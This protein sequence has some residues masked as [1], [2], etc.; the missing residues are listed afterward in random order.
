MK[1]LFL[2]GGAVLAL[3]ACSTAPKTFYASASAYD[4][5]VLAAQAYVALPACGGGVNPCSDAAT[6]ARIKAAVAAASAAVEAA[7]SAEQS[8]TASSAQ[9]AAAEAAAAAAVTQLQTLVTVAK[10]AAVT[11]K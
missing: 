11:A 1:R 6:I 2:I 7:A 9:L 8:G 4:A 5:A 3:A 10:A